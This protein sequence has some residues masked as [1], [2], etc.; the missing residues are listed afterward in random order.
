MIISASRRSDIPAFYTPWLIQRLREGTCTVPNPFNARQVQQISLLPEEVEAI[1]FWTRH[2]RPL[3][4]YLRE[5]DERGYRYY[6][7]YTVLDYPTSLD[8]NNPPRNVKI[9]TF[10]ELASRIGSERVMWRYDPIVLSSLTTPEY[11]LETF[12]RLARALEGAT[13]RVA[14]SLLTPYSKIQ[15]RML[16]L[17]KQA[18]RL[19]PP[20]ILEGPVLGEF[21]GSLVE[22]AASCSM[23]I[24]SCASEQDMIPFGIRP[25][26]C[27]DD[28]LL[29]QLFNIDVSH[30]K[31]PGQRKACGCVISK[32]I[33]MYD[34]CLFG[35]PY[36]YATNS[37]ERARRNHAR[38]DHNSK[39]LI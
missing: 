37:F 33:G 22:I 9:A 4:S 13:Q 26:K 25:G 15:K 7:Q 24:Q 12:S 28:D 17:E 6:F 30:S 23:Q 18:V 38:H 11:H 27:I 39:S 16:A 21:L 29:K 8:Q 10:Q 1:V 2:P 20:T 36:C 35:C 31:D 14:I 19:Y 5:M 32:D 34:T 3:F